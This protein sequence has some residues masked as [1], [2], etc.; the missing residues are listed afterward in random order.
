MRTDRFIVSV[1]KPGGTGLPIHTVIATQEQVENLEIAA[2]H[3]RLALTVS[4]P[5]AVGTVLQWMQRIN[6]P[7]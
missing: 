5:V 7:E 2:E 6:A 3:A 4:R 1:Y